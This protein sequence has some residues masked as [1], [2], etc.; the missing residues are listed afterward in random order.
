MASRS[1]LATALV[2]I[3]A[4]L[5]EAAPG[6]ACPMDVVQDASSPVPLS[7][8]C[9]PEGYTDIPIDY[10]D[11]FSW[12]EFVAMVWP[13]ANGQRGV[14]DT[15]KTAGDAGPR[16][17]ETFKSLWEVFHDDGS[18]PQPFNRYDAPARN[19][20]NVAT[21]FG[22][23]VLA[24]KSGFDDIGQAGVG[25]LVGPLVAQNG[26]YV[27]YQTL[28]NQIAYDYIVSNKL[29][30]RANL[31]PVPTPR[32][33]LPMVQFPVGSVAVKAAWLN[34]EGFS[35][36][37]KA[38][39]YSRRAVVKDPDTGSCSEI[40]MGLVG[41]HIVVKTRSRPQWIWSSF[42]QIDGEPPKQF[43]GTGKFTFNDGDK[44]NAMPAENPLT[45]APLAKEPATPF[46]LVRS[47]MMPIHPKTELM[48][49]VYQR[50]LHRT[51]WEFYQ[52]VTTQ[53]PRLEGNQAAPV[54][55]TQGGE[56]TTTF[57]GAGATSAFANLT[58]ETFD[59]SRPQLGCMSCHN[60]ARIAVDFLW[61]VL[62]HAY[63]PKIAPAKSAVAH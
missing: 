17:F 27:R 57:P 38:R 46:N 51:P 63:P 23:V 26:R 36:A 34:L 8:V 10:F 12:R 1:L 25:E 24:S 33:D 55:A 52:I 22:D 7:D 54:P 47:V 48:T 42:E 61:S 21:G 41:L 37:Q 32:P 9:I 15:S 2:V 20:C 58:I 59:Q 4:G 49:L 18:A 44:K 14:A 11:D 43:G 50:L 45:L 35:D 56:I 30:L 5:G 29:Y 3:F 13:A 62:D 16:V 31:P 60:Q 40:T 53:W 39:F 6:Q 28:Y 19:A